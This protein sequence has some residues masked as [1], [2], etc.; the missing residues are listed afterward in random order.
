MSTF[1]LIPNDHYSDIA[2]AI[3]EKTGG[4]DTMTSGEMPLEIESIQTGGVGLPVDF[5][6]E[7]GNWNGTTYTLT[8]SSSGYKTTIPSLMLGLSPEGSAA[9]NER[10]VDSGLTMPQWSYST[11][12]IEDE[13]TH[14]TVT[15]VTVVMVISA[16]YVPTT[17][18]HIGIYGLLP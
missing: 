4:V 1:K 10:V 14:E 17:D 16:I 15:M 13:E 8:S 5:E 11:E 3:R 2:D 6:L 12:D 18:V 7:V 9:N